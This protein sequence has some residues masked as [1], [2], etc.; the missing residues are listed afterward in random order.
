MLRT[1]RQTDKQT[2][3]DSNILPT[4]T[5]SV[6]MGNN[7]PI[8]ICYTTLVIFCLDDEHSDR[9]PERDRH[10]RLFLQFS[11][12]CGDEDIWPVTRKRLRPVR[13]SLLANEKTILVH[14]GH[15]DLWHSPLD[16]EPLRC[17]HPP[18]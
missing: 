12:R 13:V 2:D 14:D 3:S 8:Y 7:R 11:F 15:V 9:E 1:N 6:G 18:V 10:V 5:D 4:P 16:F 17:S